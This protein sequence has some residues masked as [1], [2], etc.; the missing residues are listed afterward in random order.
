MRPG[1]AGDGGG[2]AAVVLPGLFYPPDTG[3]DGEAGCGA[4]KNISRQVSYRGVL[5]VKEP[6]SF[7]YL[8]L[9]P[10]A[11]LEQM[12]Y[13][14]DFCMDNPVKMEL[15]GFT[16]G[17]CPRHCQEHPNGNKYYAKL[18]IVRSQVGGY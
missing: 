10:C 1:K 6:D 15:A 5:M 7:V 13:P 8:E 18:R 4:G 9:K 17:E 11:G 2:G 14:Q 12:E 3:T 16:K